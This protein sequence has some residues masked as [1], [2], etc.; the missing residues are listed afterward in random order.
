MP[1]EGCCGGFFNQ[2][3]EE[4]IVFSLAPLGWEYRGFMCG[5]S[6]V[7]REWNNMMA[8][9]RRDIKVLSRAFACA[10][11]AHAGQVRKGSTVPY[12]VHPMSVATTLMKHGASRDVVIAGL[13]HDVLEDTPVGRFRLRK[14]FG[15]RVA[16]L[17]AAVSE[18]DKL[19]KVSDAEKR[20]NW[21][22]RKV[23]K[24]A[25]IRSASRDVKRLVC[26]DKMDNLA[27]TMANVK[28]KGAKAWTIFRAPK[29]SQEWYY[30]SMCAALAT[31][32]HGIG[33]TVLFAELKGLVNGV[34][35][36]AHRRN[37]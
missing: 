24:I 2:G 12:I 8:M 29:R 14:M 35:G 1:G 23:H 11:K 6:I 36:K 21:R 18:P 17:V 3:Q 30:R 25:S 5:M 7:Y 16:D 4:Y 22:E 37:G 31:E 27:D 34:F 33:R 19:T 32:P 20:R 15:R 28:A 9:G 26:A 10:A 13:L